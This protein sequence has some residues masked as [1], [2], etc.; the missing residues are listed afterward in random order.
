MSSSPTPKRRRGAQPGNGNALRHGFYSK[1]LPETEMQSLDEDIQS[2][3]YDGLALVLHNTAHLVAL[4]K[5]LIRKESPH[6]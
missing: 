2:E 4:L 6:V 3:L 5:T 1:T